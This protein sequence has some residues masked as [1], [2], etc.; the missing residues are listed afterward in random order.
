MIPVGH[1][2]HQV[3]AAGE[4]PV[5]HI[6]PA[7]RSE[8]DTW[9][10]ATGVGV[11]ATMVALWRALASR[12]P[13]AL[14]DDPFAEPLVRAVGLEPF[15]RFLNGEIAIDNIMKERIAARTRFFDD[16]FVAAGADIRQSVI[17]AA[18]LDTRAYRLP[19]PA[20]MVVYEIDRPQVLDFKSKTLATFGVVPRAD[21][22]AVGVDLRED[23]QAALRSADFDPSQPTA[24]CVEGLLVY[25]PPGAQDRLFDTITALSAPGSRLATEHMPAP[26]SFFDHRA[27][28]LTEHWRRLGIDLNFS[29]LVY[30]GE[31]SSVV[32]YLASRGWQVNG[33]T[34]QEI[35]QHKGFGGFEFPEKAMVELGEL[36]FATAKLPSG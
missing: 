20:G 27:P 19:W 8:G 23:W 14:L 30:R 25:L 17:V 31:R 35:Y 6:D 15:V 7:G 10:L 29:E 13:G 21:R 26:D 22:R 34:A 18:G 32:D 16:F 33:Y 9:D 12:Q 5:T 28:C 2:G 4:A 11:T 36:D 1:H 24:W 3:L